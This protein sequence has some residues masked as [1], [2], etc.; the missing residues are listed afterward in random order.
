MKKHSWKGNIR[1]LKNFIERH[2]ILS[3]NAEITPADIS[4]DLKQTMQA[5]DDPV[6]IFAESD[7][8]QEFKETA[9]KQFL[10]QK[11]EANNWNIKATAT[12]IGTPRSNL[13]KR[14][15]FYGI[16]RDKQDEPE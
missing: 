2:I 7:S 8:L 9:E 11:L 10:I 15:Q 3:R 5:G 1:D 16:S 13:Y 12:A 14:L 4:A 6:S